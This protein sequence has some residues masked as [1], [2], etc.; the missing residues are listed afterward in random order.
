M[1]PGMNSNHE[2]NRPLWQK[3]VK[4]FFNIFG[5]ELI[6]KNSFLK[7]RENLVV[8]LDDDQDSKELIERVNPYINSATI[9]TRWSLIQ[10]MKYIHKNNIEGALL[11]CGVFQGGCLGIICLL[12]EKYKLNREIYAYDT[13]GTG[14]TVVTDHDLI[15]HNKSPKKEISR[16]H[17]ENFYPTIET[18]KNNL[19]TL[20]VK[21]ELMPKFI[22]GKVEET[23]YV[24]SNL[25]KKIALA[26]IDTDFYDSTKH[27]LEVFYP[28]LAKGGILHINDYGGMAGVKKA[29]DDYF[30]DKN[31]WMH[32]VDYTTRLIIKD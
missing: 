31:V 14:F 26:R 30:A 8:E 32:R 1:K 10:S 29:V 28:R 3:I 13:F 6:R 11:E 21:Q 25:P 12:S 24:D 15:Q 20:G 22:E 5:F 9:P 19:S 7:R 27:E 17:S 18:V 16:Q 23:L 4:S 2:I